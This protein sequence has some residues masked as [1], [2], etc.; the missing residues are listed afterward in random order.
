MPFVQG[1]AI[2]KAMKGSIDERMSLV[3][4]AVTEHYGSPLNIVATFEDHVLAFNED[5]KLLKISYNVN[6]AGDFEVVKSAPSKAIPV[7]EDENV[8]VHVAKELKR[9]TKRMMEGKKVERTQVRELAALTKKDE[10]YWMSDILAKMDES[11]GE[12]DWFRM[13]EANIERIRTSLHGRIRKI[14]ES[15]PK[16]QYGKIA[17]DK[18]GS[19]D[20]EMAESLAVI[21]GLFEGYASFC[22]VLSFDEK[23]E[24]LG[25]VRES[26]V[27]EAQ[28][29]VGLL[30]K[31]EKL[32]GQSEIS[33]VAEAHYKMADRAR[34]MALVSAYIKGK[35][36]PNDKE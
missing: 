5:K 15:V 36:Q 14:E 21:S 7:I 27:V 26:L 20:K 28:A 30:G 35:A 8:H 11:C 12:T 29:I 2:D 6:E 18:L 19:F 3:H 17:K 9:I 22:S 16:T 10:S 13:Y 33:Q 24:F 4:L 31:A 32:M 25:A 23:Q 34:T 1:S